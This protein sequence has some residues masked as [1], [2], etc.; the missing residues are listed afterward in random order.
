M[1]RIQV[2]LTLI[3]PLTEVKNKCLSDLYLSFAFYVIIRYEEI[4]FK[5]F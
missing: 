3:R 4:Y 2:N 5:K 1:I